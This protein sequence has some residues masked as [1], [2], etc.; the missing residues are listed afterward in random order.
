MS[1]YST[2]TIFHDPE[3][4]SLFVPTGSVAV[5]NVEVSARQFVRFA[6]AAVQPPQPP[7]PTIANRPTDADAQAEAWLTPPDD[8][9]KK[10]WQAQH[11]KLIDR[12]AI[13]DDVGEEL[14]LLFASTRDTRQAALL[15]EWNLAAAD[16]A[17]RPEQLWALLGDHRQLVRTASVRSLFAIRAGDPR[18]VHFV[19]FVRMELGEDA[20]TRMAQWMR[21]KEQPG[22]IAAPQAAELAEFLSHRDLA[23]RQLAV[24]LLERHA[25]PALTRAHRAPPAYDAADPAG[26]RAE[27][28]RQWRQLIRQIFAAQRTA[29]AA[30]GAKPAAVNPAAANPA[31]AQQP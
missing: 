4:P 22:Q 10:K 23:M 5:E 16:D 18:L 25:T 9:R 26:K 21:G 31:N 19:R 17:A 1:N 28:Q 15:A 13:V 6:G 30:L 7:L 14:P 27:A 29:P 2:L 12:L 8:E 20:G 11:G 3:S 24:S